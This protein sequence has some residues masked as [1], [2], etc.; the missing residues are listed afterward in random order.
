MKI[1]NLY[2]QKEELYF[3]REEVKRKIKKENKRLRILFKK[4]NKKII[5]ILDIAMI[6]CILFNVGAFVITNALVIKENPE[7]EL[8]EANPTQCKLN[9]DYECVDNYEIIS[10]VFIHMILLSVLFCYYL[11]FRYS[12]KDE[13]SL[14]LLIFMVTFIIIGLGFDFFNNLGYYIGS[15]IWG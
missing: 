12:I 5:R 10:G 1:D 11:F 14:W 7:V 15:L 4:D 2:L 8:I 3:K 9:K 6:I 13:W